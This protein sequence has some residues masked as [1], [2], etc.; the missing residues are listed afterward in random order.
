[1]TARKTSQVAAS[2]REILLGLAAVQDDATK[3]AGRR[4]LSADAFDRRGCKTSVN[5]F[6]PI[7]HRLTTCRLSDITLPSVHR[8]SP[9]YA[10]S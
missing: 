4:T 3:I 6:Q 2:P 1:M 10:S 5:L 9:T 8:P 7:E